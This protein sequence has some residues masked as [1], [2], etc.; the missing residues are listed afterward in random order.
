M[1]D[2][3]KDRQLEQLRQKIG[4]LHDIIQ[5]IDSDVDRAAARYLQPLV[6]RG[7]LKF[8]DFLELLVKEVRRTEREQPRS[9]KAARG[10][11]TKELGR[12]IDEKVDSLLPVLKGKIS[13]YIRI[14]VLVRQQQKGPQILPLRFVACVLKGHVHNGRGDSP[15]AAYQDARDR[16]VSELFDLGPKAFAQAGD[17]HLAREY[18]KAEPFL[19]E[20]IEGFTVEARIIK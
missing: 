15:E 11:I 2:T 16:L 6:P 13:D 9:D 19:S 8:C 4:K 1:S 14:P 17:P 18:A 12:R 10:A 20:V 5:S 7:H 3:D